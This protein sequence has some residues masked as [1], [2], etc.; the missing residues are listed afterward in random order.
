MVHAS[1]GMKHQGLFVDVCS[2]RCNKTAG[3]TSV[4][5][6]GYDMNDTGHKTAGSAFRAVSV[7]SDATI[8][9]AP[10]SKL[11]ES[12]LASLAAWIAGR[13][14]DRASYVGYVGVETDQ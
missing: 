8:A 13:N 1:N 7:V 4:R 2:F 6:G 10:V 14:A 5:F 3:P 9:T 12:E 11:S